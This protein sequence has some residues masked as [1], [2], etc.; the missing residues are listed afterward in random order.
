MC[1]EHATRRHSR[2]ASACGRSGE[3][4]SSRLAAMVAT[5][6]SADSTSSS[7]I[8][9]AA[10]VTPPAFMNTKHGTAAT[11]AARLPT[12]NTGLRPTVSDSAPSN[13]MRNTEIASVSVVDQ[14]ASCEPTCTTRCKW[15]FTYTYAT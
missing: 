9:I 7:T 4:V 10:A 14:N 11:A 3:M 8:C 5:P 15:M 2:T 6:I 1:D 13:G 12:M